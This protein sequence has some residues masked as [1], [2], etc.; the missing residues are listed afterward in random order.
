MKTDKTRNLLISPVGDNSCHKRWVTGRCD[1]DLFLIYYGDTPGKYEKDA[2][3]YLETKGLFK[4]EN[5]H[6]AIDKF[7][8]I[9]KR[10]ERVFIP[11]DDCYM[12][13]G[14]I[15]RLFSLCDKYDLELA[16]PSVAGGKISHEIT[17]CQPQYLLRYVFTVEMMC[18]VFKTE[19]LFELLDT[20]LLNRS[21]WGVDL[22]WG[23]LLKGRK[24]AIIDDV[25]VYH[26]IKRSGEDYYSNLRLVGIDACKELEAISQRYGLELSCIVQYGGIRAVFFKAWFK[27][28]S[29]VIDIVFTYVKLYGPVQAFHLFV[30]KLTGKLRIIK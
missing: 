4:L 23:Q 14:D 17:R 8:D 10:Y 7:R 3:Y 5:A 27:K 13:A 19:T 12:K 26:K 20:F 16:Q 29:L 9:V 1:F 21:G 11:D 22:L 28:I 6:L 30:K 25:W 2:L 18:P 15:N 24:I